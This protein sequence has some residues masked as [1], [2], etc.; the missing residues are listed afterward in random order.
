MS[1]ARITEL[2]EVYESDEEVIELMRKALERCGAGH[3][4]LLLDDTDTGSETKTSPTNGTTS[5]GNSIDTAVTST[6]NQLGQV[7][8]RVRL[9]IQPFGGGLQSMRDGISHNDTSNL[10]Q[11][12]G[13]RAKH[14]NG[15]LPIHR[16]T[17]GSNIRKQLNWWAPLV[18]VA[19]ERTLLLF[20]EYF[21]QP[22]PNTSEFWD[23][24][25]MKQHREMGKPYPQL[26]VYSGDEAQFRREHGGLVS[27]VT[28]TALSLP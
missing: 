19:P 18:P 4:H 21:Y 11:E 26:P 25:Q 24:Q 27:M 12:S 5:S 9:R 10:D 8:D 1:Q 6:H 23:F 3:Q 22:V 16:D 14:Y 28:I 2:C 17:W 7:W 13:Q 15:S 20:P